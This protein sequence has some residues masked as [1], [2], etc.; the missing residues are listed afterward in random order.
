MGG[1]LVSSGIGRAA[2]AA[3]AHIDAVVDRVVIR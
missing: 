3:P 1:T 2:R